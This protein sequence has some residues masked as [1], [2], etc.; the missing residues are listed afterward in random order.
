M[1]QTIGNINFYRIVRDYLTKC[2]KVEVGKNTSS[3]NESLNG[4][5]VF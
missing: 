5:I 3:I 1:T 4:F 2:E